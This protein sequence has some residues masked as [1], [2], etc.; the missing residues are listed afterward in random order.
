[1][2]SQSYDV[3]PDDQSATE[4]PVVDWRFHVYINGELTYLDMPR[5]TSYPY[6]FDHI[7][8]GQDD[9]LNLCFEQHMFINESKRVIRDHSI[10][11][12]LHGRSSS[13][14]FTTGGTPSSSNFSPQL[15]EEHT[16]HDTYVQQRCCGN[17]S[18]K[19]QTFR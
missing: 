16:L 11:Y 5:P 19:S 12:Y 10:N 15:P 6:T 9:L 14:G 18:W 8:S 13:S 2:I 3:D 7:I 1:M 4:L 17:N